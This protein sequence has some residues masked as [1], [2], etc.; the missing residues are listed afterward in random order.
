MS[1]WMSGAATATSVEGLPTSTVLPASAELVSLETDDEVS[2]ATQ[3]PP[4]A[5][6]VAATTTNT[7]LVIQFFPLIRIIVGLQPVKIET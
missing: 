2:S 1:T 3:V 4:H 5:A 7:M 6:K